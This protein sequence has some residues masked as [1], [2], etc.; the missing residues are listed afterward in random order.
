M[1]VPTWLAALVQLDKHSPGP[2]YYFLGPGCRDFQP[3]VLEHYSCRHRGWLLE[4]PYHLAPPDHCS[5][6][7][8]SLAHCHPPLVAMGEDTGLSS[9]GLFR[10]L[11]FLGLLRFGKCF[12]PHWEEGRRSLRPPRSSHY[13]KFKGAQ[14][15]LAPSF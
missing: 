15:G 10:L 6:S 12:S 5:Q 1:V 4:G 7:H 8:G 3:K 9:A 2:E 11:Y 14:S 13:V